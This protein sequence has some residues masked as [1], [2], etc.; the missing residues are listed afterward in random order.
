[1]STVPPH[2]VAL[3][4]M[5][6]AATSSKPR[7]TE[8]PN[9]IR[10]EVNLPQELSNVTRST[11]LTSLGTADRYGHDRTD[12]GDSVWAEIDRRDRP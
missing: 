9:A 5:L 10:I 7:I 12:D 4:G 2:A 3:A 6:A 8:T 11:I 1:M